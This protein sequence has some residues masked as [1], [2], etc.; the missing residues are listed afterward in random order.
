MKF[1]GSLN[2][3]A[4][5]VVLYIM[6]ILFSYSCSSSS[7]PGS[8]IEVN[9]GKAN[10]DTG[11]FQAEIYR[12]LLLELGYDVEEANI[13]DNVAFYTI[14]AQG[15]I[16]FWVN[17]WFPLHDVYFEMENISENLIIV[18]SEVISGG[19][20]GYLIDKD[21]ADKFGINNLADFSDP[22]IA[23]HFDMNGDGTADLI[24]CNAQWSCSKVINHHL[25]EYTLNSRITHIQGEYSELIIEVF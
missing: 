15:D 22:E 20:Q 19:L 16:D 1:N 24:G 17:G 12:Q 13:V 21:S 4:K 6:L 7:L 18:G 8:G 10:W 5:Q 2:L 23:A 25:T 14:A 11:W 3:D 9:M